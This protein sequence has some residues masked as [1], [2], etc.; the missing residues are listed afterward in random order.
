MRKCDIVKK[1]CEVVQLLLTDSFTEAKISWLTNICGIKPINDNGDFDVYGTDKN[2]TFYHISTIFRRH[3]HYTCS[4]DRCPS[5]DLDA[6]SRHDEVSD[7]TLHFPTNIIPDEL[8]IET[9]IR[10]WEQGTSDTTLIS[11]KQRFYE[12][13]DHSEY[14]S[15]IDK[16]EDVIRC[17]GWR[18]CVDSRFVDP[19]PFLIFDIAVSFREKI[20][21]L[22][23]IPKKIIVYKEEYKLGGITSFIERRT[24]YVAY[25]PD[26][27]DFIFYDGT[28]KESPVLRKYRLNHIQGDVSLLCYFPMDKCNQTSSKNEEKKSSPK[29]RKKGSNK[30][31][32]DQTS[33]KKEEKKSSPK[34]RKKGSNKKKD[35][36]ELENEDHLLAKALSE[37]E[38]ENY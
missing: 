20:K 3:Y 35:I 31:K 38:N 17:S 27:K 11:C 5:R 13:P 22:D 32:C 7:M 25:I 18:K 6:K 14:L 12:K 9:S 34:K 1:V 30:D 26:G 24:H 33:S 28:P 16:G 19:P 4:S 37:I 21:T 23:E 15:E 2:I 10:E 36:I 8:T 29:K